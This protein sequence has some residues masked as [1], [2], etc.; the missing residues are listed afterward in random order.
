MQSF[1]S[2]FVRYHVSESFFLLQ[3][4]FCDIWYFNND[5]IVIN[6]FHLTTWVLLKQTENYL[7]F[8]VLKNL[9]WCSHRIK[10]NYHKPAVIPVDLLDITLSDKFKYLFADASGSLKSLLLKAIGQL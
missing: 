5:E 3:R 6:S 9:L 7:M 10:I 4:H 8:K 1:W 2:F